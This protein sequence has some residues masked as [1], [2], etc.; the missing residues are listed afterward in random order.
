MPDTGLLQAPVVRLESH[1]TCIPD[2]GLLQAPV[3]W[4]DFDN[5]TECL[6]PIFM[7]TVSEDEKLILTKEGV[8]CLSPNLVVEW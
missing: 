3:I 7:M 5:L 1:F 2:T 4:L 8:F 6:T